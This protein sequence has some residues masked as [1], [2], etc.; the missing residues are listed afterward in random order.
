[1]KDI[2]VIDNRAAKSIQGMAGDLPNIMKLEVI[3]ARRF[4]E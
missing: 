4:G 2:G 1:M 3:P